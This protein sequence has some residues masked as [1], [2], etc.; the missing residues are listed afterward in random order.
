MKKSHWIRDLDG[1]W[2][3]VEYKWKVEF[4][5]PFTILG[6]KKPHGEQLSYVVNPKTEYFTTREEAFDY[7]NGLKKKG[8][9]LKNWIYHVKQIANPKGKRGKAKQKQIVNLPD[10]LRDSSG[11]IAA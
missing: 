5:E 7:F 2:Q 3:E 9:K 1:K 4:F 11:K 10:V 6:R 8:A